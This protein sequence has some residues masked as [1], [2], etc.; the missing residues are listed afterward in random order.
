[1]DRFS[2]VYFLVNFNIGGVDQKVI[3]GINVGENL[4]SL[5]IKQLTLKRNWVGKKWKSGTHTQK[6]W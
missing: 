5:S 4:F 1:M 2:F 6:K 3:E